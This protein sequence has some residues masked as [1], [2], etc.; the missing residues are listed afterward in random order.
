[1]SQRRLALEWLLLLIGGVLLAAFVAQGDFTR[2]LSF[3]KLDFAA[4]L[5]TQEP[6]PDI[7][8]VAIDERSLA[9]LG[10]WPSRRATHAQLIDNLRKAGAKVV[11]YDVLLVE[12]GDPQDD[13]ALAEAIFRHGKVVLPFSF[14]PTLNQAEGYQPE[15]PRPAFAKAAAALGPVGAT[16]DNDGV[17][18]RFALELRADGQSYPHF[19]PAALS[20]NGP[21]LSGERMRDPFTRFGPRANSD[22]L[23]AGLGL[24]FVKRV[25]DAHH[26][27]I[28]ARPNPGGGT[29]FDIRLPLSQ[30]DE[31]G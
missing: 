2:R 27:Q 23:S 24:T 29:L 6:A 18:R 12:P 15:Y 20:L 10:E 22:G 17:L 4:S 1:M 30:S 13:A 7:A 5:G 11:L 8:I 21:G 31:A 16:P 14:I 25:V 26:G 3:T 19:A 28:E 9:A